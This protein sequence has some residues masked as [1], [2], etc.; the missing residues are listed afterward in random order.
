MKL[1]KKIMFALINILFV[2]ASMAQTYTVSTANFTEVYGVY[3]QNNNISGTFTTN[4]A[5]TP[6][7]AVMDIKDNVIAYNFT[8]GVQMLDQTNSI[9]LFFSAQVNELNELTGSGI[10]IWRAPI[11]TVPDGNVGG[12]DI[13]ISQEFSQF[14]GFLDGECKDNSGP[15]GECMLSVSTNTNSGSYVFIDF[16]FQHGFELF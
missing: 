11:T 9:I 6:N 14:F 8:D 3:S 4:L 10:T 5:I 7:S 2:E 15:G 13:Y 12:M 16:I 1:N